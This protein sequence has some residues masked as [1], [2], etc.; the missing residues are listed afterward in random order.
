M[1]DPPENITVIVCDERQGHAFTGWGYYFDEYPDE[2]VCG[3]YDTAE[4]AIAAAW[5]AVGEDGS[6]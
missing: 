6:S 2:G 4:E 3:P 5:D 1:T